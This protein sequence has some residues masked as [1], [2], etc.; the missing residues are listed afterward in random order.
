MLLRALLAP[1]LLL[2]LGGPAAATPTDAEARLLALANAERSREGLPP[3]EWHEPLA[4]LARQQARDMRR[5]G[6]L[7][8]VSADGLTYAQ[9]VARADLRMERVAEN[10]GRAA[11]VEAVHGAL[12]GSPRHRANILDGRLLVAGFGVVQGDDGIWAVQD[13]GRPAPR[14]TPEDAEA[15]VLAAVLGRGWALRADPE[16]SAALEPVVAEMAEAD[17]ASVKGREHPGCWIFGLVGPDPA[18]LPAE[19]TP[20]CSG[21][22]AGVATR[23]AR[24]PQRP[25]GA[26]FV[27][28]AVAP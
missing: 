17:S 26:W 28:I 12:M 24:T 7:T 14:M 3:L 11:N 8:H 16:L 1:L 15:S 4:V 25:L 18:D 20:S 27:A 13:F 9:R 21:T 10:V 23:W 19:R 6:D 22:R 5:K 2:A